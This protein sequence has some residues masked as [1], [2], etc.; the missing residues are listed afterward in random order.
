M[1]IVSIAKTLTTE[2]QSLV[3]LFEEYALKLADA[4]ATDADK[5]KVWDDLESKGRGT[6][7]A[8]KGEA[9]KH[10]KEAFTKHLVSEGW[11]NDAAEAQFH[12]YW[13]RFT[14][15]DGLRKAKEDVKQKIKAVPKELS[16]V[17]FKLVAAIAA[18]GVCGL[19]YTA[20]RKGVQP[21]PE[22]IA[23]QKEELLMQQI[24]SFQV[25]T[26]QLTIMTGGLLVA[27]APA[28]VDALPEP[29][30]AIAAAPAEVEVT[31][32]SGTH[33]YSTTVG[34]IYQNVPQERHEIEH[35][36]G[37]SFQNSRGFHK[38]FTITNGDGSASIHVKY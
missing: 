34:Q 30:A 25:A 3:K 11:T 10:A 36:A 13:R 27:S 23:L 32:N 16:A 9:E 15:P 38:E 20:A 1:S 5:S 37:G 17:W 35:A 33:T 29:V 6:S 8:A 7:D 24:Q 21:S 4:N 22:F 2:A 18:I 12:V 28:A 19:I 14:D 31:N 26:D